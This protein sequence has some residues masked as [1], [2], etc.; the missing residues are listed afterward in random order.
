MW[1]RTCRGLEDLRTRAWDDVAHLQEHTP[2]SNKAFTLARVRP[3]ARRFDA[4][5][6]EKRFLAPLPPL[7]EP[8][9]TVCT[10]SVGSDCMVSFEARRYSVPFRFVGQQVEVRGSHRQVQILHGAQVIAMHPR[11]TDERILIDPQHY[12]G[13]ST[14]THQP[15]IP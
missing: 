13:E 10:R 8:F 7:P 3:P 11:G 15:P 14:Q 2:C 6:A 5:Q 1:I 9:D 12:T 4:Y